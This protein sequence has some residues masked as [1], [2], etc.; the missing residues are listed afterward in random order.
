MRGDTREPAWSLRPCKLQCNVG[1]QYVLKA[2]QGFTCARLSICKGFACCR[3]GLGH[4]AEDFGQL[5][6]AEL[7]L[8]V[9]RGS[10]ALLHN[11]RRPAFASSSSRRLLRSAVVDRAGSFSLASWGLA[12]HCSTVAKM[13]LGAASSPPSCSRCLQ[14]TCNASVSTR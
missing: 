5:A 7:W 9:S 1:R 3:H 4:L 14:S 12:Q 2:L 6:Q 8:L 13:Q 11:W 10:L